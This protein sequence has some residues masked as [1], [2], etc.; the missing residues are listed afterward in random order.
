MKATKWR[1]SFRPKLE[2]LLCF[3][4]FYGIAMRRFAEG[5][6]MLHFVLKFAAINVLSVHSNILISS[7][8]EETT[9]GS[10]K[11]KYCISP[12][13]PLSYFSTL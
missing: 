7:L 4:V 12:H 9:L 8:M 2:V 13:V 10:L 11:P 3:S 6:A 1:R 5:L